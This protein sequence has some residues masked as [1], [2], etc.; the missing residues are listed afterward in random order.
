MAQQHFHAVYAFIPH[1]VTQK[2][3]YKSFKIRTVSTFA[4]LG[5]FFA[6]LYLGHVPC[7]FM[8][9]FLQVSGRLIGINI[10]GTGVLGTPVQALES[11]SFAHDG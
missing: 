10:N 7:L 4:I 1:Y 6:F 5:A 3:K 2:K 11:T 9:F 8:L